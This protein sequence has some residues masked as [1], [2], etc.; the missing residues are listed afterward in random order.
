MPSVAID[1]F[2]VIHAK[3]DPDQAKGTG[4]VL[5]LMA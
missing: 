3:T 5:F 4:V 1:I 2:M